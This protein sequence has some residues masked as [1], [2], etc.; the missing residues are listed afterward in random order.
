MVVSSV[1]DS[2]RSNWFEGICYITNLFK[3]VSLVTSGSFFF[4]WLVFIRFKAG[5]DSVVLKRPDSIPLLMVESA[6]EVTVYWPNRGWVF[7]ERPY[8]DCLF[9]WALSIDLPTMSKT[10]AFMASI[11]S[12]G[13]GAV[14]S[15][16]TDSVSWLSSS[17]MASFTM[18]R[19]ALF[20]FLASSLTCLTN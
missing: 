3:A 17:L 13:R 7:L 19:L 20:S 11:G 16:M 18:S 9:F 15:V 2:G 4:S 14:E 8:W 12:F 10:L 6:S 5:L 1:S